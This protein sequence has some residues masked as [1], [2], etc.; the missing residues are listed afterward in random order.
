L[1]DKDTSPPFPARTYF[2]ADPTGAF[3]HGRQF[4]GPGWHD[5]QDTG[6]VDSPF[7]WLTRPTGLADGKLGKGGFTWVSPFSTT[8]VNIYKETDAKCQAIELMNLL[9]KLKLNVYW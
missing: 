5:R 9:H 4:A 8:G 6:N 3:K 2:S 7:C 1:T